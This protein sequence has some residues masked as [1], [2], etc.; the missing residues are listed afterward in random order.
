VIGGPL[1]S[2]V[3]AALADVDDPEIPGVSIIDLGLLRR[4]SVGRDRIEVE[5][6]PT[7]I[8][9]PALDVIRAA[10][11]NRLRD[12]APRIEV[13]FSFAEP[14]TAARITLDGR[15]ALRE[16]GFAPPVAPDPDRALPVLPLAECP[17]CGSR[18]AT[19][20]NAF[21]ATLC[22]AIYYCADCRQ[23]FEQFKAA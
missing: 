7:F 10:V 16:R 8:G 11:E 20:E 23:P 5:L 3:L 9:C 15:A 19:L 2:V 13:R 6:L 18:R 17:Y 4:V 1:E 22:R 14:W 21:G 12:L